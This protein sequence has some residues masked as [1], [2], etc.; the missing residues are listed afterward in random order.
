MDGKK[1][2]KRRSTSLIQWNA[3]HS[4]RGPLLGA[5]DARS[6]ALVIARVAEDAEQLELPVGG[7]L[8][9]P[10]WKTLCQFLLTL[11]MLPIRP[12]VFFPSSFPGRKESINVHK[13]FSS[14]VHNDFIR[15][16]Q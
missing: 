10:R 2:V 12:G 15:K 4:R 13:D 1:H 3:D 5:H 16:S 14:N 8:V 11:H 7:T 9:Q 6:E